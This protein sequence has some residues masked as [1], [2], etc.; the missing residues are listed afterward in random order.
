MK[1]TSS[2]DALVT[3]EVTSEM[4]DS[5]FWIDELEDFPSNEH[6]REYFL[7]N[8]YLSLPRDLTGFS[9]MTECSIESR[10]N[11][12]RIFRELKRKPLSSA[13]PELSMK[14]RIKA[15]N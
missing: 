12:E 11:K 8:G 6:H 4:K 5:S 13:Y 3:P 10:T 9:Q 15:F 2:A 14:P 1:D 7:L